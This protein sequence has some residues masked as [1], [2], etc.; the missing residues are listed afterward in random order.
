MNDDDLNK[1]QEKYYYLDLYGKIKKRHQKEK[2]I[3]LSS[4]NIETIEEIIN[5]YPKE[6][7][8]IDDN[9]CMLQFNEGYW[10]A[11]KFIREN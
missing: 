8:E 3:K 2:I 4:S 5:L 11:I 6:C 9:P 10:E 1:L 7:K